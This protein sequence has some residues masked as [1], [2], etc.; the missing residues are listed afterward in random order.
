MATS[1]LQR[2]LR[3]QAGPDEGG[4]LVIELE[5]PDRELRLLA[6]VGLVVIAYLALPFGG[7]RSRGPRAVERGRR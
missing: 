4:D 5:R 2:R 3:L 1:G 7:A 6:I